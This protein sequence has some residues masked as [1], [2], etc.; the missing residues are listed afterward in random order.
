MNFVC[1]QVILNLFLVLVCT[2]AFVGTGLRIFF[3][4]IGHYHSEIETWLASELGVTVKF[5]G[6]SA[7][8][9]GFNPEFR[10]QQ[11]VVPSPDVS[12]SAIKVQEVR[13]S[14][15]TGHWLKHRERLAGLTVTLVGAEFSAYPNGQGQWMLW[16]LPATGG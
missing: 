14:W 16:G 13:I 11:W 3:A 1:K 9:H 8:W 4:D 6:L 2:V 10:F 12:Q 15:D 5:S 7:S